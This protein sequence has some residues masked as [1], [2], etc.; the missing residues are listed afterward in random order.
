MDANL[1]HISYEGRELEDP[2]KQPDQSNVAMVACHQRM[3]P[4][5][6]RYLDLEFVAGDVVALDGEK[7]TQ[8]ECLSN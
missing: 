5:R 4:T 2:A 6:R 8:Q 1:L 7:L 3:R